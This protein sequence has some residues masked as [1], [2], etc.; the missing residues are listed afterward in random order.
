MKKTQLKIIPSVNTKDIIRF[1]AFNTNPNIDVSN[2]EFH[3]LWNKSFSTFQKEM[4]H[5]VSLKGQVTEIVDGFVAL[6]NINELV[7]NGWIKKFTDTQEIKENYYIIF[8]D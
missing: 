6:V 7:F 4:R 5:M 3:N 8:T 1:I 2:T